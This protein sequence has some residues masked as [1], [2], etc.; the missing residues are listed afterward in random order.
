[1]TNHGDDEGSYTHTEQEIKLGTLLMTSTD[2]EGHQGPVQV[3]FYLYPNG[4]RDLYLNLCRLGMPWGAP[5]LAIEDDYQP[6]EKWRNIRTRTYGVPFDPNENLSDTLQHALWAS[7]RSD[8]QSGL[9]VHC[10]YLDEQAP[11]SVLVYLQ[12]V[13]VRGRDTR[14][15]IAWHSGRSPTFSLAG[16]DPEKDKPGDLGDIWDALKFIA[17]IART[18]PGPKP[19]TAAKKY[20]TKDAWHTALREKVLTKRLASTADDTTIAT[21]LDISPAWLYHLM[22]TWGPKTLADLREGRF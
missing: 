6:W 14:G 1:M 13:E 21:W 5:L 22:Q 7:L 19:G 18:K 4:T 2:S 10:Y 9:Q 20:P 17:H 12:E 16:F 11:L 3:S 15:E 8:P